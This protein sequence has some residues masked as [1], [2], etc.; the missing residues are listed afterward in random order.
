MSLFATLNEFLDTPLGKSVLSLLSGTAVGIGAWWLRGKFNAGRVRQLRKEVDALTKQ[1]Y[2]VRVDLTAERQRSTALQHEIEL[3]QP[4]VVELRQVLAL[5][6]KK[7]EFYR[8]E[9]GKLH[10]AHTVLRT[11][12]DSL[13]ASEKVLRENLGD[14]GAQLEALRAELDARQVD[15]DQRKAELDRIARQTKAALK[16]EGNLWAARAL[17]KVRKFRPLEAR[18]C[19]IVT[20]LNLKGGV[21]KTTITGQLGIAMARRGHRVLMLDLDLQGSLSQMFMDYT[22]LEQLAAEKRLI[23]HFLRAAATNPKVKLKEYVQPVATIPDSDGCLDIVAASDDLAYAEFSLTLNWLLKQGDRDN[24]FLLR[25]AVQL[26]D[27][28]NDYDLVLID[29]PPLVN[30]SCINALAASDYLLIP[31][32]LGQRSMDRVPALLKRFLRDERFRKSIN[33]SLHVLGLVANR[34]QREGMTSAE[35]SAW[36]QLAVWCQEAYDQNVKRFDTAILQLDKDIRQSEAVGAL[37]PADGRLAQLFDALAAEI[38][39]E[40]PNECRIRAKALS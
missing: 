25:R 38:E 8:I 31:V 30:M 3:R 4:E 29:C 32:T 36:D 15:L 28:C 13:A 7:R 35:R 18:Q 33:H 40:L 34:V 20:V 12:R 23:H 6:Q 26:L 24:R 11:E 27:V 14:A 21:G 1:L 16:L 37:P 2:G 10:H 9:G 19:P 22:T 5:C 17:Q 39:Q